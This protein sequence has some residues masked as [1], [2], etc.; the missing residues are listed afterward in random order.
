M[1]NMIGQFA[2]SSGEICFMLMIL[3]SS[4]LCMLT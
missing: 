4:D 3:L 2:L 1:I